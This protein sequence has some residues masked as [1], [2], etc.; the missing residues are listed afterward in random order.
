MLPQH[1]SEK[2][3]TRRQFATNDVYVN[4]NVSGDK[5][6]PKKSS[7]DTQRAARAKA[8]DLQTVCGIK[9]NDQDKPSEHHPTY[10]PTSH[11]WR[12]NMVQY[13][14]VGKRRI[15]LFRIQLIQD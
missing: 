14:P 8:G 13:Y 3:R 9:S 11:C 2:N 6:R 12:K 15:L 7:Q 10:L 4:C 1:D 5:T